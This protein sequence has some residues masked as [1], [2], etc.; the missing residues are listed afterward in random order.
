MLYKIVHRVFSCRTVLQN[1]F[2]WDF[3]MGLIFVDSK[4]NHWLRLIRAA[5]TF[6]TII[7]KDLSAGE[8]PACWMPPYAS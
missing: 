3:V 8:C 2:G 5:G 6:A 7:T 1:S 4:L